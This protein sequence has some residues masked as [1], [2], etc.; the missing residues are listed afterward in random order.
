MENCV[1]RGD[2]FRAGGVGKKE[3][4][5]IFEEDRGLMPQWAL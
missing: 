4:D 5:G 3:G 1:K 2:E